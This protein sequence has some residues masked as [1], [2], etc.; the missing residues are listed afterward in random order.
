MFSRL[1][2]IC[3]MEDK[4]QFAEYGRF[5]ATSMVFVKRPFSSYKINHFIS[6]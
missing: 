2:D 5:I 3:E 6:I 1:S 4:N